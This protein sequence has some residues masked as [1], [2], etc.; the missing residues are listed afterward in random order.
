MALWNLIEGSSKHRITIYASSSTYY[1]LISSVPFLLLTG[2]GASNLIEGAKATAILESFP[3]YTEFRSFIASMGVSLSS[4]SVKAVGIFGVLYGLWSASALMRNISSAFNTI[5]H[6]PH[7]RKKILIA[8]G[9][10][11]FVP[12]FMISAILVSIFSSMIAGVLEWLLTDTLH[13][14]E[15]KTLSGL[16][17]TLITSGFVMLSAYACYFFLAPKR[18][19]ASSAFLAAFLFGIYFSALQRFMIAT[20]GQML[21]SY[22]IYGALGTLLLILLWAYLVFYGLFIMGE[23]A[24]RFGSFGELNRQ[25]YIYVALKKAPDIAERFMFLTLPYAARRYTTGMKKGDTRQNASGEIVAVYVALGELAV[26]KNGK[27]LLLKG[28]ESETFVGT[29]SLTITAQKK[30][31]VLFV[32]DADMAGV[33][34]NYPDLW[35]SFS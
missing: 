6:A 27:E 16:T 5:F 7:I 8:V 9:T 26:N 3:I 31:R 25:H 32:S 30:S 12:L 4:Y 28:G 22:A 19:R 23:F 1:F 33:I 17:T 20:M 10:Y 14:I 29:E 18:P 13:L 34:K 21:T 15:E 2:W 35:D 11:A 24:A